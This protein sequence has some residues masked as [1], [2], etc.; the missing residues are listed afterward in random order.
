MKAIVS[1]EKCWAL[2]C[3]FPEGRLFLGIYCWKEFIDWVMLDTMGIAL[4]ETRKKAREAQKA[5]CYNRTR[6]EK[7]H[8]TVEAIG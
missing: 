1:I 6:V 2:S 3:K 7:V 4:F 5:C 8:A